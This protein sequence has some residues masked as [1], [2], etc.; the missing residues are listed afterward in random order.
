MPWLPVVHGR[1]ETVAYFRNRVIPN[2]DVPI[3]L[4][5]AAITGFASFHECWLNHL[6]VDPE[7]QT[8]GIG[9]SLLRHIQERSDTLQL[10]TFQQNHRARRFYARHGFEEAEKTDGC[11]NEENTPDIR[12]VWMGTSSNSNAVAL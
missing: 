4:N 7:Y 11:A 6:Y 3:A 9:G 10:W 8:T 1:D 12:L 5:G 2:E